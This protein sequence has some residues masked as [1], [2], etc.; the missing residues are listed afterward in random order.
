MSKTYNMIG[1]IN[2]NLARLHLNLSRVEESIRFD[3]NKFHNFPAE[4]KKEWR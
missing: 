3:G 4:G 1:L 2:Y